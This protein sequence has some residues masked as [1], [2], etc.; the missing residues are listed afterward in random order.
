[1]IEY[2]LEF[3]KNELDDA[4]TSMFYRMKLAYGM[5]FLTVYKSG[6]SLISVSQYCHDRMQARISKTR[7][8]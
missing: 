8:E 1:M 4:S 3:K 7:I 5:L 2:R 6:S